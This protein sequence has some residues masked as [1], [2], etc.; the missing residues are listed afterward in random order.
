M[1]RYGIASLY[2]IAS[3]LVITV[4]S[5]IGLSSCKKNDDFHHNQSSR[6]SAEVLD[7]SVTMQIPLMKNATGIQNQAFSRH[8][9][10]AGIAALEALA[11]DHS[12]Y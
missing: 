7:K 9:V 11:P 2:T 10:Y 4:I 5:M 6:H 12:S 1:G 8:F 3:L